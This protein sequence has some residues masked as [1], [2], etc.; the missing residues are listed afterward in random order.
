MQDCQTSLRQDTAYALSDDGLDAAVC[1][2][3]IKDTCSELTFAGAKM[4]LYCVRNGEIRIIK[5]DR[6]SIGYK[7]SDMNFDFSNYMISVEKETVFYMA[8]DGFADQLGTDN[9]RLGSRR[10][11]ELL[12]DIAH[13]PF[14][15][16]REILL[17]A[18]EVHKGSRQRQDD[19][20]VAGFL[21]LPN[22]LEFFEKTQFLNST[23]IMTVLSPELLSALGQEAV[24]GDSA[25][26][27]LLIDQIRSLDAPLADSL[28]ALADNFEYDRILELVTKKI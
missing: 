13:L 27:E 1:S 15:K 9:R 26:V 23:D 14:E 16:Q 3:K 28:K 19:V 25:A 11:G 8:S 5:G 20:T 10:F 24:R 7:R 18:Y 17:E 22:A 4:P 6:Q 2:V 12:K 21:I